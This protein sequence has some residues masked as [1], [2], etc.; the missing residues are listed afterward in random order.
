[1]LPKIISEEQAGF[2]KHKEISDHILL[3]AQEM[4]HALYKKVRGG[5]LVIKLDMTKAFDRVSWPFLKQ[6]LE[7][8]GFSSHFIFI[9]INFLQSTH[10]S[11]L[12]NGRPHGFFK[13]LRGVKQG[14]P[15]SPLLFIIA[16]EV[17]TRGLKSAV[18]EGYI[19]PYWMGCS[20]YPITHLGFADDL[21]IFINGEARSILAFK[22]FLDSYQNVSG[23]AVNFS[24]STFVSGNIPARRIS[25]IE[26]LLG[27]TKTS[28]PLKYLGSYLHKGEDANGNLLWLPEK[29][30]HF[31]LNSAF[32]E[33]RWRRSATF[34]AK[35]IWDRNQANQIKIFQWKLINKMLPISDNL[36]RCLEMFYDLI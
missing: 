5:N 6:V 26:N 12:V 14:D 31:S 28:L 23:Q 17:F 7:R 1:M 29:E 25:N 24:K 36:I 22:R 20:G 16:S 15:L 27:M 30:G 18:N 19:K 13:P 10:L 32:H 33:V 21:L 9:I 35:Q 34:T 4:V 8:F 11:V 3:I 2:M